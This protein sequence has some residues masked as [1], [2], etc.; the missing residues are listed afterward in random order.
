MPPSG[1]HRSGACHAL[2]RIRQGVHNT[3]GTPVHPPPAVLRA[4]GLGTPTGEAAETARGATGR[5]YR[6]ETSTGV[7]AL[8]E[9][10]EGSQSSSEGFERQAALVEAALTAGIAAPWIV[11]SVEGD[12]VSLVEGVSWR[13]F[14]WVDI[15]GTPSFRQAGPTL[16]RL[17]AAA[18]PTTEEVD[19]KYRVRTI[20][21]SWTEL[22]DRA[23]EQPWA[24]LLGEQIPTLT[25]LDVMAER[26]VV[27]PCRMCHGDFTEDNVVLDQTGRVVVLDWEECGPLPPEWEVGYVLLDGGRGHWCN[28]TPAGIRE[29][30]S[31]YRQEGGVFAPTGVEVF[32]AVLIARH[33]FLAKMILKTLG[34]DRWARQS[35]ESILAHPVTFEGLRKILDAV[36]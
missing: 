25:A 9:L 12:V 20:G 22:L 14:E 36:P 23:G 26:A 1:L 5:V 13:A 15:A 11:R 28:D 3:T 16:A 10:F 29:L 19:P 34:G 4:F 35:V 21:G 32:S 18:W 17:H 31:A 27:P 24:P 7:W 33:N 8:K 30:V 6:V 2:P